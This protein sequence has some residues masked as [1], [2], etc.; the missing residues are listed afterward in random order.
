MKLKSCGMATSEWLPKGSDTVLIFIHDIFSNL[1]SFGA[2]RSTGVHH[3]AVLEEHQVGKWLLLILAHSWHPYRIEAL[4]VVSPLTAL[5][6]A[7]CFA[8]RAF[9][10][11]TI[12]TLHA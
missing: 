6:P 1:L 9:L 10:I 11:G 4:V 12:V 3:S 2:L 8:V 5:M 7:C